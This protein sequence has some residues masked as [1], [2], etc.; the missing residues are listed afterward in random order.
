MIIAQETSAPIQTSIKTP[1]QS[2]T[3]KASARAFQI[4]SGFYSEPLL[5]IPREL[6]ANA[7]D[8]HVAAGKTTTPFV[9][10]APNT[11]EPWFSIRDFGTGLSPEAIEKIY[12][13]YFESTKTSDNDSDGCMGLGSKTPFNYTQNFSVTSW[14][15]G[16]KYVYNCFIDQTGVPSILQFDESKTD[17]ENGVEVKFAVKSEDIN[18]FVNKIREAYAPFRHKP[19]I[20]GQ[21]IVYPEVKILHEGTDWKARNNSDRYGNGESC[22]CMGNYTYPIN[23]SLIFDSNDR[24]KRDT[25]FHKLYNMLYYGNL[26]LDFKIGD[27][28]VAPNKEQLQYDNSNKTR[29]AIRNKVRVAY[30]E[31]QEIVK[32]S[33][34]TPKTRWEAMGLYHKYNS[35]NGPFAGLCEILGKIEIAFNTEKITSHSIG[36]ES[37]MKD[38]GVAK[39]DGITPIKLSFLRK[40]WG[41]QLRKSSTWNVENREGDSAIFL[42]SDQPSLKRARIRYYLETK[43]TTNKLPTIYLVSDTSGKF[44]AFNK[45]MKHLGLPA[46]DCLCIE[47]L[48]KPPKK[49]REASAGKI[50][51]IRYYT[52][53]NGYFCTASNTEID[54]KETQYYVDSLYYDTYWKSNK[55]EDVLAYAV[56]NEMFDTN[57]IPKGKKVYSVNRKNARVLKVGKWINVFDLAE[58]NVR[59]DEG[60][61]AHALYLNSLHSTTSNRMDSVRVK[62]KNCI[63]VDFI[64]SLETKDLFKSVLKAGSIP[65]GNRQHAD[66]ARFF[67]ISEKKMPSFKNELAEAVQKVNTKYMNLFAILD[68][69]YADK[70][71]VANIINFIDK[72]S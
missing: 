39:V 29:D 64:D 27:L 48:P 4:L 23:P 2:F 51:E 59:T 55:I 54:S 16:F 36:M 60:V 1:A 7:W 71:T 10:H 69:Y 62:I 25:D 19:T 50:D 43:Y 9:V 24:Y 18:T 44:K 26:D 34:E 28:E 21:S 33:I 42:Y 17:D 12:T 72:N 22:A 67:S 68:T 70:Q 61:Y 65:T 31:L 40:N 63:A 30:A 14:Y 3:I 32:K 41:G 52:R 5:A 46:A 37:I 38:A 6:G 49:A 15:G 58:K 56:M 35:G 53:E 47:D 13:T 57:K 45:I 8:S 11:L 20:V 66:V